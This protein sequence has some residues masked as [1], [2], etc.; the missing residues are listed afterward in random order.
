MLCLQSIPETSIRKL[1]KRGVLSDVTI[2]ELK[3]NHLRKSFCRNFSWQSKLIK[4]FIWCD[5]WPHYQSLKWIVLKNLTSE[6]WI[7][8]KDQN[9]EPWSGSVQVRKYRK[10]YEYDQNQNT[11]LRL[12]Q[13]WNHYK[14]RWQDFE[15]KS[16]KGVEVQ[17]KKK[18]WK[19]RKI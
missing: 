18:F 13:G 9:P 8:I 7:K 4:S 12:Q 16:W 19:R 2:R 15:G 1:S 10:D 14:M 6:R 11:G 5:G 3:L 17:W